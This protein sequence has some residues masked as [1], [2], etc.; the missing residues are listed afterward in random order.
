MNLK[1]ELSNLKNEV[2]LLDFY[3]DWCGPCKMLSPIL[4]ELSEE[5]PSLKI[6]KIN[7]DEQ[8]EAAQEFNV[9]SIPSLIF[10]KDEEVIDVSV[11]MKSKELLREW[12]KKN[13]A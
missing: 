5:F 2:V 3:A 6:L 11:G 4:E 7:V 8:P 13:V 9:M 10:V 12:I 1:E